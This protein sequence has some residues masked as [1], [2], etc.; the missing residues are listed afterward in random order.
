VDEGSKAPLRTLARTPAG[1]VPGAHGPAPALLDDIAMS[2][3][4]TPH[5]SA[6]RTPFRH[7]RGTPAD[8]GAAGDKAGHAAAVLPSSGQASKVKRIGKV[9]ETKQFRTTND[10]HVKLTIGT[11]EVD[12]EEARETIDPVCGATELT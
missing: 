2:V 7:R 8:H 5:P 9:R 10:K 6:S 1:A 3:D 4:G 11:R 12:D